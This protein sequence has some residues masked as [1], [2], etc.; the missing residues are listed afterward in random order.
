MTEPTQP[1]LEV[2]A[3]L[4]KPNTVYCNKFWFIQCGAL[5]KIVM[6]EGGNSRMSVTM[7][8]MEF[9][10]FLNAAQGHNTYLDKIIQEQNA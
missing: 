7:G 2:M 10:S 1:T 6:C 8:A 9:K 4:N 3:E 5:V